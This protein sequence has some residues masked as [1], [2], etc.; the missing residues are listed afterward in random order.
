MQVD[1]KRSRGRYEVPAMRA[2]RKRPGREP[3]AVGRCAGE[4]CAGVA[5]VAGRL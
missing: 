2:A 3:I 4:A 5:A 1:E